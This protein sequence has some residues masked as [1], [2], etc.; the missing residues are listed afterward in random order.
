MGNSL[1]AVPPKVKL[2]TPAFPERPDDP[3]TPDTKLQEALDKAWANAAG[4]RKQLKEVGIAIADITEAAPHPFAHHKGD[5]VYYAASTAKI[6]A[7]HGIYQLRATLRLIAE[8]L[9]AGISKGELLKVAGKHLKSQIK[10]ALAKLPALKHAS[11]E[12]AYPKYTKGFQV[13]KS[14]EWNGFTVEFAKSYAPSP[15]E[16]SPG[17]E[18]VGHIEKMIVVSNNHSAG[19]CVHAC[20]LG[21]MNGA[22]EAAGCFEPKTG[23]NGVGVWL[24]ADYIKSGDENYENYSIKKG[25][26]STTAMGSSP[27]HMVKLLALLDDNRLFDGNPESNEGML[28]ALAKCASY[29]EVWI[30]RA[31]EEYVTYVVTHNKLGVA[32]SQ[33]SEATLLD[34]PASGKR[35]ALAWFN[36]RWGDEAFDELDA[37]AMAVRDTIDAYTST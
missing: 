15:D 25:D 31:D 13:V 29:P 2:T 14:D 10:A 5:V 17:N 36:M 19:A 26:G 24:G 9:G 3:L 8:E 23:R 4:K 37:I 35:F 32:Q 11:T 20:G 18:P 28:A 7:L 1:P 27:L 34:H 22:M 6:S 16:P 30:T 33:Y 21:F 12:E